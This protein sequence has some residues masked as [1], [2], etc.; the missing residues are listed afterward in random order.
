VQIITKRGKEGRPVF[1][2]TPSVG[3]NWFMD[4]A[5]RVGT[6]YGLDGQG[7][8]ITWNPVEAEEA[9][10][11]PL[12]RNGTVQGYNAS[13][14]G[15][16]ATTQYRVSA[17]YDRDNGI[18]PSNNLWRFNSNLNV[19]LKPLPS[20]DVISS[21]GFTKSRLNQNY[22]GGGGVLTEALFGS[23][24]LVS[25][26]RRGFLD[27]PPETLWEN[28]QASQRVSRLIGSLQLNHRPFSWLN[29]RLTMGFDLIGE[30]IRRRGSS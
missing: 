23:P 17:S 27:F 18:E 4:A 19:T 14:S 21:L 22:E 25:T 24:A 11:T 15:G 26:S 29:H 8:L 2:L 1:T 3:T 5:D 16:S 28:F 20:V 9:R 6:L 10:G 7:N 12:F 13:L 30:E